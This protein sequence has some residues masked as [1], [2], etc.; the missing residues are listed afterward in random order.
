[1]P[2]LRGYPYD[3]E[4]YAYGYDSHARLDDEMPCY[5]YDARVERQHGHDEHGQ[6]ENGSV[7]FE[8]ENDVAPRD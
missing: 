4:Q 8:Q 7:F 1:M 3:D 6:Y 2:P 5:V